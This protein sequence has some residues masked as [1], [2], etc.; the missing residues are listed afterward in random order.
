[1]LF[2]DDGVYLNRIHIDAGQKIFQAIDGQ[3]DELGEFLPWIGQIHSPEDVIKSISAAGSSHPP[4]WLFEL[5]DA[6]CFAGIISMKI[7]NRQIQSAE[8][9]YWLLKEFRAKGLMKKSL[10]TLARFA[11]TQCNVTELTIR[12][13]PENAPSQKVAQAAGFTRFTDADIDIKSSGDYIYRLVKADWELI[14]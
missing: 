1:M 8:F 14:K 6:R 9:G 7:T 3:R 10:Q 4:V 12:T 13:S 2:V 5:L 11:F